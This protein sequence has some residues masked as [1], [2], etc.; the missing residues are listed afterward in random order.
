MDILWTLHFG[1]KRCPSHNDRTKPWAQTTQKEQRSSLQS[2]LLIFALMMIS[3]AI[4][5]PFRRDLADVFADDPNTIIETDIFIFS[6]KQCCQ[7][8]HSS[9]FSL[10]PYPWEE[11]PDNISNKSRND[12]ALENN[13]SSR[14]HYGLHS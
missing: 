8:S 14:L 5:Y 1:V 11:A 9:D 2:S 13:N 12:E 6:S 7:H 10:K 3:A 4:I